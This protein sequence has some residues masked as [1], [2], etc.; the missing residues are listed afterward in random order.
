MRGVRVRCLRI[1]LDLLNQMDAF[2]QQSSI[3]V[4]NREAFICVFLI[5]SRRTLLTAM[6]LNH[7]LPEMLKFF[8]LGGGGSRSPYEQLGIQK[9]YQDK[10]HPTWSYNSRMPHA[11]LNNEVQGNSL[12]QQGS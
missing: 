4:A 6:D 2:N 7:D 3:T 1:L 12:W 11:D 5:I 8:A 9:Y 10:T